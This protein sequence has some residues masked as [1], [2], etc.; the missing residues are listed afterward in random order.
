[1]RVSR[2]PLAITYLLGYCSCMKCP[3]HKTEMICPACIGAASSK[4]K[5]V[6]SRE[7]GKLGGRPKGSKNKPKS[8]AGKGKA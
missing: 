4:R 2:F 8:Q 3:I 7:N 6:T 5:A 1:M